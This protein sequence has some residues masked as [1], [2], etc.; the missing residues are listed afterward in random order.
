LWS[1][2]RKY[3]SCVLD[4]CCV[5]ACVVVC[6]KA[7]CVGG[8]LEYLIR[9]VLVC[10]W[11]VPIV[12]RGTLL[13]CVFVKGEGRCGARASS[14][15]VGCRRYELEFEVGVCWGCGVVL[16]WCFCR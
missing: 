8:G 7:W 10:L 4:V 12:G 5:V 11:W 14:N 15:R 2:V 16:L 13:I 6:N 1:F 9:V 3:K